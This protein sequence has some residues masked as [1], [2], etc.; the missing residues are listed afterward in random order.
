MTSLKILDLSNNQITN[1]SFN[2]LTSLEKLIL[3]NNL[4]TDLNPLSELTTLVELNLLGNQITD[5][6]PLSGLTSLRALF[7]NDTQVANVN[8]LI[9]LTSLRTLYLSNTAIIDLNPLSE[10]TSLIG[11]GLDDNQIADLSPLSGLTSLEILSLENNLI[12]DISPLSG[13]INLQSLNLR[14]NLLDPREGSPDWHVLQQLGVISAG[15]QNTILEP[16]DVFRGFSIDDFPGWKSSSWYLNYNVDFWP[17]IYHDEHGWQFVSGQSTEDD[18]F[19]WDLGLQNWIFLNESF[20]RWLFVF[21]GSNT[22]WIWT[23]D[24]NTPNRRFFQRRDDR[25]IFSVPAG[26]PQD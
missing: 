9:E 26:L 11:L 8:P 17:W 20:Y 13:L 4:F 5:L 1:Y 18:I 14:F 22:G 21:G 15:P 3:G 23:F 6:N 7:L 16:L 25:S 19:L 10:L 2:R 12:T 24:D